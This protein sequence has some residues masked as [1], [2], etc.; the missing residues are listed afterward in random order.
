[1]ILS[2]DAIS[3]IVF[4]RMLVLLYH[5]HSI[6]QQQQYILMFQLE[7]TIIRLN[8]IFLIDR[9]I[10]L[11][12]LPFLQW[13]YRFILL[14]TVKVWWYQDLNKLQCQLKFWTCYLKDNPKPFYSLTQTPIL[15]FF[16]SLDH[17]AQAALHLRQLIS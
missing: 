14:W 2:Q 7:F 4:L 10:R 3:K 8:V 5:I 15:N 1:M 9:L 16:H 11:F 6:A 12:N 17:R 13:K